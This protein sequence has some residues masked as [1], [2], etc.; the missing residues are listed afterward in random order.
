MRVEGPVQFLLE[1]A[2][3]SH[4]LSAVQNAT[5][6]DWFRARRIVTLLANRLDRAAASVNSDHEANRVLFARLTVGWSRMVFPV[7]LSVVRKPP[8]R[9]GLM[10]EVF[11]IARAV[12]ADRVPCRGTTSRDRRR[13]MSL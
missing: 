8:R 1:A 7:L 10:P 4:Q 5:P 6:H 13:L 3:L 9:A 11:K 2:S 12:A